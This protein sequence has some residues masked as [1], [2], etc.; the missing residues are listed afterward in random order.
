MK[1]TFVTIIFLIAASITKVIGV[2]DFYLLTV[3][4]SREPYAM[5]GHSAIRI[6]DTSLNMDFIVDWGVFDFGQPNFYINFAR[7]KMLYTTN[8]QLY[9]RFVMLNDLHDKGVVSREI[10]LNDGQKENLWMLISYNLMPENRDYYYKFIQDNCATRP[11]DLLEAAVGE[12]L[13]YPNVES[14]LTF[15]DILHQYQQANLWYNLL[16]DII[17]G[18]PIDK[19]ADFRQQMFIPEYLEQGLSQADVID[20]VPHPLLGEPTVVVEKTPLKHTPI[21][22]APQIFFL[23]LFFVY[24]ILDYLK[25]GERFI[26]VLDI[27]FFSILIF[28]GLIIIF[29]WGFTDHQET[30]NN[31]NILWLNPLLIFPLIALT[32]KKGNRIWLIITAGYMALFALLSVTGLFPQSF[33]Y[34]MYIIILIILERCYF[35]WSKK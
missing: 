35:G 27:L 20:L 6:V 25:K 1:K 32:S 30:Y 17:L 23:A 31:F 29:L 13:C 10:L 33:P 16:I 22:L 4:E 9:E 21:M 15:R 7:G 14:A 18:S 34:T 2:P 5:Y 3:G 12:S 28:F 19:I 24:L 11:R 8:T 26:K